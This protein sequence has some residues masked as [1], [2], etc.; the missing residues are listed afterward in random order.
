[1]LIAG[2]IKFDDSPANNDANRTDYEVIKDT[3]G[4]K[5]VQ[6]VNP[7][8]IAGVGFFIWLARMARVGF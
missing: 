2:R 8:T 4:D 5:L 3:I 6:V 7:Y 1:M